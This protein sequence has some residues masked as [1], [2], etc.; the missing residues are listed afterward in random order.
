MLI[1]LLFGTWLHVSAARRWKI[2]SSH[3]V[4]KSLSMTR[5]VGVQHTT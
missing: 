3:A 1:G 2:N 4:D 5:Y